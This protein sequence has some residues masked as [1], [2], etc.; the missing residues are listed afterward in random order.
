MLVHADSGVGYGYPAQY[1]IRPAARQFRERI[2]YPAALRCEFNGVAQKVIH[3]PVKPCHISDTAV[4]PY[5]QRMCEDQ[6][7][8]LGQRG[9]S[10]YNLLMLLTAAELFLQHFRFA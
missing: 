5:I 8:S 3:D 10:F 6:P 4:M 9:N 7:F 1:V 2:V